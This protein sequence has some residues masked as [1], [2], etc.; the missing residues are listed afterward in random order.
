MMTPRLAPLPLHR[1]EAGL[2]QRC[3]AIVGG[4]LRAEANVYRTLAN[5]PKLFEAWLHLG[6][7]LLRRSTLSAR[8]RELVI[9]RTTA[10]SAGSYPFTQHTRIGAEIGLDRGEIESVMG[11]PTEGTFSAIE[12][13]LLAAVDQLLIEGAIDGSVWSE[14]T[15]ELTDK[16]LLDLIATVAFYRL[17]SWTLNACGTPLDDGDSNTLGSVVVANRP[18]HEPRPTARGPVGLS[19]LPLAEWPDDLMTET[20]RWPRFQGRPEI[21]SAGVYCTLANHPELFTAAGPLMAHLLVDNALSDAN[22][23]L[24]IVRS[25]LRDRGEYPYRQHVKIGAQVGLDANLLTE[26]TKPDPEPADLADRALVTM[27][28]ELHDSNTISTA[29]W[30]LTAE[31]FS[32]TQVLDAMAT[33]GFYGLISFVLS[34]AAVPLEAGDI[35]L[36]GDIRRKAFA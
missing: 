27:I 34:S 11:G 17:A 19:P 7:H 21:R 32:P 26:L 31:H 20:A 10:V 28:D 9:L 14:L 1:W 5:G 12:R 33:A 18:A 29:T 3:R 15:V 25:T 23:E 16:Q 8:W 22:R 2:L 35:F 24:V 36:P 13:S 30:D 4:D 6:G